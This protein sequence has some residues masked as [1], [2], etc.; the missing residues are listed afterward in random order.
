[1]PSPP[2]LIP[3]R[4]LPARL[5]L[6]SQQSSSASSSAPRA[7]LWAHM[8][9]WPGSGASPPGLSPWP[10][11]RRRRLRRRR[12]LH[13]VLPG[14]R[15]RQPVPSVGAAAATLHRGPPG[16]RSSRG[17]ESPL[18]SQAPARPSL[19][20]SGSRAPSAPRAPA[21]WL[22]SCATEGTSAQPRSQR[23]APR[24]P[25][26]RVVSLCA[27]QLP[28]A[29]APSRV[30]A[31]CHNAKRSSSLTPVSPRVEGCPAPRGGAWA[32]VGGACGGPL[33]GGTD[34]HLGPSLRSAGGPSG[35]TSRDAVLGV[36]ENPAAGS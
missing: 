36:L 26:P 6:K 10:Q 20:S 1:M 15:P 16:A 7:P 14:A 22:R 13:A 31:A 25:S 23:P 19:R 18:S 21:P 8:L 3:D 5:S 2:A 4:S 11:P 34:G 27:S 35:G 17:A 33:T 30:P 24:R 29:P 28:A 12:R 32:G 9:P